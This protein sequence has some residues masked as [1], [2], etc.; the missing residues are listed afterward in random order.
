MSL[1]VFPDPLLVCLSLIRNAPAT[2]ELSS[3]TYGTKTPDELATRFPGLPYAALSLV[4]TASRY[5]FWETA[6]V[7]ISVWAETPG[8]AY[9]T[10]QLIRAALIETDGPEASISRSGGPLLTSDPDTQRPM[11]FVD[12]SV[13]LRPE[14]V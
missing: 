8:S 3:V 9:R 1:V 13:R 6:T 10:V 7:R 11:A 14:S 12:V 4:G 2:A 5:P